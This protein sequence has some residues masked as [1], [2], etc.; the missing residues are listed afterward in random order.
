MTYSIY[1]Y[2]HAYVMVS[3]FKLFN[4]NAESEGWAP[5]GSAVAAEEL[6][7]S[8]HNRDIVKA[9]DMVCELW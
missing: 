8:S 5:A 1:I 9:N 3:S 4:S 6:E 2:I 7:L